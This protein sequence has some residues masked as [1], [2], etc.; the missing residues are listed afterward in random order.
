MV[1]DTYGL[2][3]DSM[4]DSDE[5][6]CPLAKVMVLAD[7]ALKKGRLLQSPTPQVNSDTGEEVHTYRKILTNYDRDKK[8]VLISKEGSKLH[9]E[10]LEQPDT[11]FSPEALMNSPLGEYFLR[12]KDWD[13]T[14]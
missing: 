7:R 2:D 14:Q 5:Q 11:E 1:E 8:L 6:P 4:L 13:I 9:P 3:I 10:A 12:S